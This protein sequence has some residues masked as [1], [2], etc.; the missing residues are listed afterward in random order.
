MNHSIDPDVPPVAIVFCIHPFVFRTWQAGDFLIRLAGPMIRGGT[1]RLVLGL[2]VRLM[3][4]NKV[5]FYDGVN[6][7]LSNG[8]CF[9]TTTSRVQIA[10]K[11]IINILRYL[12]SKRPVW[13]VF[14]KRICFT[15]AVKMAENASFSPEKNDKC[16]PN[17]EICGQTSS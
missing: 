3:K 16:V 13:Q 14:H 12:Y 6:I 2:W 4:Q 15:K 9:S 11:T 1:K 17:C 7:S 8:N 5:T 10:P